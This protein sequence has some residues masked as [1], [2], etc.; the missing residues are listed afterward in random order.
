M[1][2][3]HWPHHLVDL[4]YSKARHWPPFPVARREHA[5]GVGP[6][7][8]AAHIFRFFWN[9]HPR[10]NH[11]AAD[12][13]TPI[14]SRDGLHAAVDRRFNPTVPGFFRFPLPTRIRADRDNGTGL[15]LV[16]IAEGNVAPSSINQH[17]AAPDIGCAAGND[18]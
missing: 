7:A 9:R 16:N 18:D 13:V 8:G 12:A 4:L 2:L 17:D 11:I 1:W 10:A 3:R 14:F 6:H 15:L 5:G